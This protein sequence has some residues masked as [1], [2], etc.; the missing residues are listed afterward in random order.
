M[1][2]ESS[3][4]HIYKLENALLI[5]KLQNAEKLESNKEIREHEKKFFEE[6]IRKLKVEIENSKKKKGFFKWSYH[7]TGLCLYFIEISNHTSLFS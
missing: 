1:E 6:E 3:K 4:L 2:R 5:E 7:I